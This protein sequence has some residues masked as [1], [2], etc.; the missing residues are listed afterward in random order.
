MHITESLYPA[1]IR[2]RDKSEKQFCDKVMEI[3]TKV[4]GRKEY[5][6]FLAE[7]NLLAALILTYGADVDRIQNELKDGLYIF[8]TLPERHPAIEYYN[9]IKDHPKHIK[10]SIVNGLLARLKEIE[11]FEEA[12]V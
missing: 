2:F 11:H 9:L 1:R 3:E 4:H 6:W 8:M 5:F 10:R 7:R 12:G